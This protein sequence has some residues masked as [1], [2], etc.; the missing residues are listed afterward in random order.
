MAIVA[1]GQLAHDRR[2]LFIIRDFTPDQTI[3]T[4]PS[5]GRALAL[6]GDSCDA[7]RLTRRC[8]ARQQVQLIYGHHVLP[9]DINLMDVGYLYR[10]LQVRL[11]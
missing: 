2:H 7:A 3:A 9:E 6:I 4:F 11:P 5:G 10:P 8:L 1:F